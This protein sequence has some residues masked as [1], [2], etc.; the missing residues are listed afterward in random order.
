MGN[1]LKK[2]GYFYASFTVGYSGYMV[3]S[4]KQVRDA[5]VGFVRPVWMKVKPP[6]KAL[7][8]KKAEDLEMTSGLEVLE[9]WADCGQLF[10]L[11]PGSVDWHGVEENP[12]LKSA[13]LNTA[14]NNGFPKPI[15]E[16]TTSPPMDF[17]AKADDESFDSIVS[18]RHLSELEDCEELVK[19]A[20]RVLKPGGVF[21]A[22]DTP[23]SSKCKIPRKDEQ[24]INYLEDEVGFNEAEVDFE[25]GGAVVSIKARKKRNFNMGFI[26]GNLGASNR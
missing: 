10:P 19:E 15:L 5:F 12:H 6:R 23:G 16:V 25:K 8:E 17:L 9:L 3:Y 14:E 2:T 7:C 20:F 11:Y 26:F 18:Q 1:A 21:V 13:I 24:A 22:W 4:N